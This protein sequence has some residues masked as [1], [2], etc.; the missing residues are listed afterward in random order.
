MTQEQ[1]GRCQP[2]PVASAD[3]PALLALPSLCREAVQRPERDYGEFAEPRQERFSQAAPLKPYSPTRP[4][5]ALNAS[6]YTQV[7]GPATDE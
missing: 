5:R 6:S 1:D 7:A 3:L 4:V 2:R